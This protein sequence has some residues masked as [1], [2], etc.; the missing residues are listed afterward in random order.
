MV[1]YM[2]MVGNLEMTEFVIR[3]NIASV[4]MACDCARY[5]KKYDIYQRMLQLGA[6]AL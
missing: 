3:R 1:H 4:E 6:R 2:V 5:F